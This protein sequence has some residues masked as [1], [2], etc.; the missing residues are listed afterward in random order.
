MLTLIK[1]AIEEGWGSFDGGIHGLARQPIDLKIDDLNASIDGGD[2]A[3]EKRH[4]SR[5][6]IN[7]TTL[8]LNT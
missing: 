6:A 3:T 4:H 2:G 7:G 8:D 5:V 1:L